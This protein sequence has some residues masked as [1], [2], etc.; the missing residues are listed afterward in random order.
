MNKK[1]SQIPNK[2]TKDNINSSLYNFFGVEKSVITA[3]PDTI[4]EIRE[5]NYL[6]INTSNQFDIYDT[7][8]SD[9]KLNEIITYAEELIQVKLN[10]E[11]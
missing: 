7:E 8:E 3:K 2:N 5:E 11:M 4:K 6:K 9:N 1:E 10:K